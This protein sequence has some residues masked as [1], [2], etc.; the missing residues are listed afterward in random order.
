MAL[1]FTGISNV[2]FYSGHYLTAVLEGDLKSLFAGWRTVCDTVVEPRQV[3]PGVTLPM[4]T[5]RCRQVY[6]PD[7]TP[8]P[9]SCSCGEY[10]GPAT[11]AEIMRV[12]QVS[13]D[14]Q[15]HEILNSSACTNG[16][17]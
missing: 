3:G 8:A 11:A 13:L 6:E 1:D 7:P 9:T 17:R 14:A 2:E 4:G 5:Q 12:M 15:R 16:E 10:I